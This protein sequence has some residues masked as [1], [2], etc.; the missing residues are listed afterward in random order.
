MNHIYEYAVI[1]FI[2]DIERNERINVG[3]IMMC[4]RHRWIRLKFIIDEQRIL[5]LAP[6]SDL[7]LLKK[8]LEGFSAIA[9]GDHS[10]GPI[11]ILEP[12]ERF[13]WLTSVKSTCIQ[14]SRPHP[15]ITNN[16]DSTFESIYSRLVVP[17]K[18]HELPTQESINL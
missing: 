16:L 9:A 10:Y 4:K 18:A 1:C 13:R 2:P 5:S 6:Y 15:G 8:Q 14:T 11:A 3:L 7:P 12:E 17:I